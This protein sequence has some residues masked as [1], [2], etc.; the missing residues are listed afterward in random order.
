MNS[1]NGEV[2][3]ST[4]VNISAGGQPFIAYTGCVLHLIW[5]NNG[6]IYYKRNPTGNC[7]NPVVIE[8]NSNELPGEYSLS[9]NYPNPFNP[10]TTIKFQISSFSDV[11]I[12]V[13]DALG[14]EVETLVNEKKSQGTYEVTFDGSKYPSGVYF[15]KLST[16]NFSQTKKLL[17]IK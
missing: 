8:L 13:Y 11:K 15:Y 14:C 7:G 4:P 3:W 16:D 2:T 5:L 10:V 17:L 1:T 12:V 6:V 9:Q